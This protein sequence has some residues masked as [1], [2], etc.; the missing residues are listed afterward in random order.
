MLT[1]NERMDNLEAVISII[2]FKYSNEIATD[3]ELDAAVTEIWN[4][5][6]SI[7]HR[8]KVIENTLINIRDIL[9]TANG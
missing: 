4:G 2:A 7:K 9:D 3:D 1:F 5:V 6:D 8:L